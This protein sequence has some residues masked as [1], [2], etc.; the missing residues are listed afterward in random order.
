MIDNEILIHDEIF[1]I[2]K[3]GKGE[4]RESS[5]RFVSDRYIGKCIIQARTNFSIRIY[6][7][8]L[9]IYLIYNLIYI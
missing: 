4:A 9:Y 7:L 6:N 2:A 1:C 8:I 5:H 3:E